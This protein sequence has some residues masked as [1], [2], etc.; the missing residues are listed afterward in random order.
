MELNNKK[1]SLEKAKKYIEELENSGQEKI[2]EHDRTIQNLKKEHSQ[3]LKMQQ[4][5]SSEMKKTLEE[6]DKIIQ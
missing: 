3:A 5:F 4:N 1:V 6:K 2:F